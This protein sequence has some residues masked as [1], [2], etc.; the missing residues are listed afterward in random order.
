MTKIKQLSDDELDELLERKEELGDTLTELK[1]K[2]KDGEKNLKESTMAVK[3]AFGTTKVLILKKKRVVLKK[4]IS[5]N[6]AKLE[7]NEL[8]Q[9]LAS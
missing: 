3:K 6:L 1:Y 5:E 4:T 7:D 8:Y 9:E 2:L